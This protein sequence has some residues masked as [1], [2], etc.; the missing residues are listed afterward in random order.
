MTRK[1]LLILATVLATLLALPAA[2]AQGS[3]YPNRPI[4]MIVPFAA[5][6]SPDVVA[7]VIG[8]KLGQALGQPVI[9]D[10][11]PG[12]GGMIGAEAAAAG[13]PDGYTLFFTVKAV[14]AI[15][16]HVYSNVKYNALRDF[17]AVT[18]I[19]MR[20]CAGRAYWD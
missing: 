6:I 5:G 13:A 10:N 8:D 2:L 3:D 20:F 11:K 19:L 1:N 16:P 17:K 7:R 12:A 14:M 18:Q 15:A 4:K 9:I